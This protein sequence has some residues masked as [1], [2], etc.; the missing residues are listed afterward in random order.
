MYLHRESGG[1]KLRLCLEL[2]LNSNMDRIKEA[3]GQFIK[4]N[5]PSAE[6]Y[7]THR[8]RTYTRAVTKNKQTNNKTMYLQ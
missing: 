4:K 8:G 1:Q 6:Y 2:H 5:P 7:R 3:M